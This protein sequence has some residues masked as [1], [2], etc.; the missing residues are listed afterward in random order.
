MV[1]VSKKTINQGTGRVKVIGTFSAVVPA[2][3][4][5]DNSFDGCKNADEVAKLIENAGSLENFLYQISE[6]DLDWSIEVEDVVSS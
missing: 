5:E 4:F 6:S 1:K 3:E 2:R